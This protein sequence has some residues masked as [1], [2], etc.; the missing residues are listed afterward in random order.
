MKK[1]RDVTRNE[2]KRRHTLFHNRIKIRSLKKTREH[3]ALNESFCTPKGLLSAG[4][5][6]H[7]NKKSVQSFE[8][9]DNYK[10]GA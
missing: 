5:Q 8:Y 3:G 10:W 1:P 9:K 6:R 4:G 7:L 2:R